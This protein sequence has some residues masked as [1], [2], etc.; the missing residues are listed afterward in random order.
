MEFTEWKDQLVNLKE[1]FETG[2]LSPHADE[3]LA[4]LLLKA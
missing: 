1:F 3:L 4:K 2:T